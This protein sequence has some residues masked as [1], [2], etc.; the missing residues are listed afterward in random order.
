MNGDSA[1]FMSFDLIEDWWANSKPE[2]QSC[3]QLGS[4]PSLSST[5]GRDIP[6][7]FHFSRLLHLLSI[8][9]P[10][11]LKEG[12]RSQDH[13]QYNHPALLATSRTWRPLDKA[14]NSSC[15]LPGHDQTTSTAG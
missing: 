14:H 6:S 9:S 12:H 13:A 3:G 7:D 8:Y 11:P 5:L 4:H 10:S 1:P 2:S 15:L